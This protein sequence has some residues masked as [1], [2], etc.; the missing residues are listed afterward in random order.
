MAFDYSQYLNDFPQQNAVR[1]PG[2][3]GGGGEGVPYVDYRQ[4][5][6]GQANR[7]NRANFAQWGEN[8]D[9]EL[10]DQ[11]GYNNQLSQSYRTPM[12]QAYGDLSENPGWTP[13]EL[14]QITRSNAYRDG[15][16]TPDEYASNYATDAERAGIAGDTNSYSQYF[17]PSS[18]RGINA[19]QDVRQRSA[20][21][22]GKGGLANATGDLIRGYGSAIDNP[23]LGVSGDYTRALGGAL[24]QG[25]G[26]IRSALS[27][28][29][30]T[31]DPTLKDDYLMTDRELQGI[32]DNA[33]RNVATGRQARFEDIKRGALAAGNA[34]PMALAALQREYLRAADVEGANAGTNAYLAGRNEQAQR[35]M[36]LEQARLDAERGYSGLATS[37]YQQL[38]DRG[39]G[40]ANSAEN[41]RLGAAQDVSNRRMQAE[42]DIANKRFDAEQWGA[43]QGMG[44]E[45]DIANRS[46][47]LN[48]Y[49]TD[50]GTRINQDKDTANS[51]RAAMNYG[52]RQ[53]NNQYAQ[54]TR[55]DQNTGINDRQ[56]S[57]YQNAANARIGGQQ[58]FR[59]WATGQTNDT[60]DRGLNYANTRNQAASTTMGNVNNAT[61]QW[62][63][64]DMQRRNS[65]FGAAFKKA[66]GTT[67]GS[68]S[69]KFGGDGG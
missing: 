32:Q 20:L 1:R 49:I 41:L 12:N 56:S 2:Y 31:L 7:E 3:L 18:M 17:D 21:D 44:L 51:D 58:E 23:G 68:P 59:N 62:G 45:G 38:A 8:V 4:E 61:G 30:L 53:G 25:E 34:D 16:T 35:R 39:V 9:S 60:A 37:N 5:S 15:M 14:E 54:Q 27:Q 11:Y 26:D 65:G 48:Q 66:L 40:A 43:N 36:N 22:A 52:I 57:A 24:N 47:G 28:D 13:E 6:P 19:E 63:D 67:L 46:Q 55:F 33:A 69:F 29:R 64:Y 42:G 50:T 10:A